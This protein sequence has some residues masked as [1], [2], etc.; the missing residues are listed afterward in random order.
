MCGFSFPFNKPDLLEKWVKFVKRPSWKPSK[1][2]VICVKHFQKEYIINGQRKKLKWEM[3]PVPTLHTAEALKRP[4]TLP[5]TT[6]PRKAPKVRMYQDDEL[7]SY[8]NK[9]IITC[10]ADLCSRDAPNNYFSHETYDYVIYYNL[11]FHEKSGFSSIREAMKVGKNLHEQ[12]QLC[13][14]PVPL[15]LGMAHSLD[16]AC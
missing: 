11:V 4:S 15:P 12:L 5:N 6:L 1:S 9:D 2:S 8:E 10:F 7:N 3:Q 16:T 14:K 13:S